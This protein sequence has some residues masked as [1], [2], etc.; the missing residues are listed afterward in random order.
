MALSGFRMLKGLFQVFPPF[1][2]NVRSFEMLFG[3]VFLK[4][5]NFTK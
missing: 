5:T 2:G 1:K 3:E 4:F